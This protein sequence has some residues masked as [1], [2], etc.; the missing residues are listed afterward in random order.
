MITFKQINKEA[1]KFGLELVKGDSYFYF[2]E[3]MGNFI[4]E[5]VLVVCINRLGLDEWRNEIDEAK[6]AM[7]ESKRK[8]GERKEYLTIESV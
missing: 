5:N 4:S 1:N 3:I 2:V 7:D 8:A 6:N